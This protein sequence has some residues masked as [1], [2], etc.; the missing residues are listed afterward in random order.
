MVAC[1]DC[2]AQFIIRTLQGKLRIG[3]AEK[4]VLASL[5]HAFVYA[6]DEKTRDLTTKL[7]KANDILRAVYS[8]LPTYDRIIPALLEHGIDELATH[9]YLTPGIPVRPM[10]AHPTKSVHEVFNRFEKAKFT[11][12][13]KYDGE[14]AQIHWF[15][16]I[17]HIYSRNMENNTK[18]YPD[19]VKALPE[20]AEAGVE[21]CI[22]D[23]E[24]VAYDK[25]QNKILSFQTLSTRGRKV[26]VKSIEISSDLHFVFV[27]CDYRKHQSSDL[28]VCF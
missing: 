21:S 14:R 4:T 3:L 12:E 17:V 26:N 20:A 25:D 23:C 8:Q 9:C 11:C 7:S 28:P 2:E 13:F 22:L 19:I 5:A 27:G 18:K 10:L 1:R 16:N 15:N 6:Y 24:V